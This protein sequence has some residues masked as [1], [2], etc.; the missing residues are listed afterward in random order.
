MPQLNE[1]DIGGN[2]SM[3]QPADNAHEVQSVNETLV[4]MAAG[5]TVS[6]GTMRMLDN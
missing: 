2:L 4:R 3:I 1:S 5:S 6:V